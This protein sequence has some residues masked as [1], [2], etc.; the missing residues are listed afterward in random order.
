MK[1]QMIRSIIALSLFTAATLPA[2]AD[3]A[4]VAVKTIPVAQATPASSPVAPVE[5]KTPLKKTRKMKK[6]AKST[7]PATDQTTGQGINEKKTN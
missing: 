6:K 1:T 7:A 2:Y 3:Q 4:A 5:S